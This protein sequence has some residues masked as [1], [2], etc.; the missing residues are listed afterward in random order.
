MMRLGG[1]DGLVENMPE[2]TIIID[3]SKRED[4]LWSD[5]SRSTRTHVGRAQKS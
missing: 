3:L 5:L 4:E 1:Y 2:A